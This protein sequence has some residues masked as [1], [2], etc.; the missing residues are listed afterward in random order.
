MFPS[1]N[2]KGRL[3]HSGILSRGVATAAAKRLTGSLDCPIPPAPNSAVWSPTHSHPVSKVAV[4]AAGFQR[5]EL[6]V[7]GSSLTLSSPNAPMPACVLPELARPQGLPSL[8]TRCHPQLLEQ[9]PSKQ[10]HSDS[11]GSAGGGV[12]GRISTHLLSPTWLA[13]AHAS[14]PPPGPHGGLTSPLPVEAP[15]PM[16]PCCR[17]Q[18]LPT[19][20]SSCLPPCLSEISGST[21]LLPGKTNQC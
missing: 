7:E 13:L 5:S 6:C 1:G 21:P 11:E 3:A 9:V 17:E 2:A 16:L 14:S 12:G 8:S 18:L 15:P 10:P 20:K 19:R 4:P